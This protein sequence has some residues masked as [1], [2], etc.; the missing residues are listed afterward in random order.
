MHGY[1]IK[2]YDTIHL[3]VLYRNSIE[4]YINMG[5]NSIENNINGG[6]VLYDD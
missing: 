6:I 5:K 2:I 3:S 1:I 4:F